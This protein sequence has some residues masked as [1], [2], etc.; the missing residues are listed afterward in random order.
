[1][2]RRGD[3]ALRAGWRSGARASGG[4]LRRERGALRVARRTLTDMKDRWRNVE[5][6]T[7]SPPA[8]ARDPAPVAGAG[9]RVGV[10][11][12]ARRRRRRGEGRNKGP[13]A[14]AGR[15]TSARTRGGE[16]SLR[17]SQENRRR[18]R[19]SEASPGVHG[20]GGG[21]ARGGRG[22]FGHH[23]RDKWARILKH[24]DHIFVNRTSVDLKDKYRNI[25]MKR[26]REEIKARLAA[27]A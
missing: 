26:A 21:G 19:R 6:S 22:L 15:E 17:V 12:S 25:T 5:R 23:E 11:S 18:P 8:S 1:M 13:D 20:G 9:R 10:D 3:G 24:F 4:D 2:D 14:A 7:R 16:S 27:Q